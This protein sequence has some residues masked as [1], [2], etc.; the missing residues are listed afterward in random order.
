MGW[1]CGSRSRPSVGAPPL[2]RALRAFTNEVLDG[3][4]ATMRW[5]LLYPVV[6]PITL[7][8]LWDDE[9]F[10]ALATRAVRLARETGALTML[11]IA[12][13]QLSGVHVFRGDFAAAL[14]AVQE[15]ESISL[16]TGNTGSVNGAVVLGAWRGVEAEGLDLITAGVESATARGEGFVLAMAG[17]A[18][19]VLYNGLAH[20]E[21][22]VD[23]AERG[24]KRRSSHWL[25]ARRAR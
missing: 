17:Y 18:R 5:L 10:H 21:A 25:V 24:I 15:A 14:A 19:S 9:A 2:R 20:Y 11:P 6:Q 1:R 23:A 3:H 13:V 22:A 8:A 4:E 12:L 16:A 7:F